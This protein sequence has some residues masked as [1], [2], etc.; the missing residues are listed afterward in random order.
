VAALKAAAQAAEERTQRLSKKVNELSAELAAVKGEPQV[1]N[2]RAAA[3]AQ[4]SKQRLQQQ[5]QQ[6]QQEAAAGSGRGSSSSSWWSSRGGG[7][8]PSSMAVML[9][10]TNVIW[11]LL[12]GGL[13]GVSLY[14]R[15]LQRYKLVRYVH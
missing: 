6:Q 13:C 9:V 14:R 15:R 5:Q 1:G 7:E 12:V 3:A 10:A 11:V 2:S 8:G 4:A